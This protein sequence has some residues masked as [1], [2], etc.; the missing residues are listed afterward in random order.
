MLKKTIDQNIMYLQIYKDSFVKSYPR[1]S[2][3]F[4]GTS[5]NMVGNNLPPWLE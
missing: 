1:E 5:S 3:K 4:W 2:L